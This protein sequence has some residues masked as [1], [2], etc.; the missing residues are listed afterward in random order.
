MYDFIL[1]LGKKKKKKKKK[2]KRGKIIKIKLFNFHEPRFFISEHR[3]IELFLNST[4]AGRSDG[5][6]SGGGA[7]F[8]GGGNM[9]DN[10]DNMGGNM[11][12]NMGMMGMNKAQ[13]NMMAQAGDYCLIGPEI[14]K[15]I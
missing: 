7:G 8:G 13:M 4:P 9:A 11:E 10:F 14:A 12:G 6:M 1:A 5:G 2:K 3:Y 15:L